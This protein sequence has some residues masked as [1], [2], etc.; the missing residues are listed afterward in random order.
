MPGGPIQVEDNQAGRDSILKG[1]SG[2]DS[3]QRLAAA[4][5]AVDLHH[6]SIAWVERAPS[7]SNPADSPS[8]GKASECAKTLGGT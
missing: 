8:R 6:P 1:T 3:M 7:E 4:F 2:K 5:H